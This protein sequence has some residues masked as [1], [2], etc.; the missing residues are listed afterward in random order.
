[1]PTLRRNVPTPIK[2]V[3]W[4]IISCNTTASL[5][6]RSVTSVTQPVA[7]N[8]P[9]NHLV[10]VNILHI[11]FNLTFHR[12]SEKRSS[13]LICQSRVFHAEE[14]CS[15]FLHNDAFCEKFTNIVA[16]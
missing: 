6:D 10:R 5:M 12:V 9:V 11:S 2:Y 16:D 4:D 14:L 3:L 15:Y 8:W 7:I 13:S 1:M